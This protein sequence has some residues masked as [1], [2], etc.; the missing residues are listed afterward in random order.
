MTLDYLEITMNNYICNPKDIVPSLYSKEKT[1]SIKKG[2]KY[3]D[4]L[5]LFISNC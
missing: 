1:K 5:C 3:F 4:G 2:K